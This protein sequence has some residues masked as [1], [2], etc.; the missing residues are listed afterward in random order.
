[1]RATKHIRAQY[2]PKFLHVL[3]DEKC[4]I[5]NI[6]SLVIDDIWIKIKRCFSKIKNSGKFPIKDV[7][8]IKINNAFGI[9]ISNSF[10]VFDMF[11][12]CS[13]VNTFRRNSQKINTS[14]YIYVP[15]MD[16]IFY[17]MALFRTLLKVYVCTGVWCFKSK[18]DKKVLANY[19][20][21]IKNY[22]Y[23][24]AGKKKEELSTDILTFLFFKEII[25]RPMSVFKS[26]LWS[27]S[28]DDRY[29][30]GTLELPGLNERI[31]ALNFL[32][33][34]ILDIEYLSGAANMLEELIKV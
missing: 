23:I 11:F 13:K 19:N 3:V 9:S 24:V 2:F 4:G 25:E 8:G 21:F 7:M 1:M 10:S 16:D 26:F 22:N 6:L 34:N 29:R 20:Y 32:E 15:P 17:E 14:I 30:Y 5:P 28:D 27:V 33:N 31:D 12:T 18:F